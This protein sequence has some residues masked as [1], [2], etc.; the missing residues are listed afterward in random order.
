MPP[1]AIILFAHGS[2]DPAWRAPMEAV[3]SRIRA[4]HPHLPVECAFLELCEPDLP[5]CA[6]KIIAAYAG[7]YSAKG[8]FDQKSIRI[9]PMFLGMGKHARE[10]LPQL[11]TELRAAHRGRRPACHRAFGRFGLG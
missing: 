6:T 11:L 1:K 4:Q 7:F 3:A 2:R 9:I 8:P 5:T 10:D